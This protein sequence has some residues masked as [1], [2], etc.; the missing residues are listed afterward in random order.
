MQTELKEK[1]RRAWPLMVS[2]GSGMVVLITFLIPSIQDQWDRYQARKVIQEY[3]KLGDEFMEEAH[4]EMAEAA[5]SKAYDLSEER[6]IDIEMKRLHAKIEKISLNS[7]WNSAIPNDIEEVDFLMLMHLLA[8]KGKISERVSIMNTYAI[9]LAA[10]IRFEEAEKIIKEAILLDSTDYQSYINYG[11]LSDQLGRKKDAEK[12]YKK[13]IQL[14]AA[15]ARA[16]YNLG[17]LYLELGDSA[18]AEKQFKT[19]LEIEPNDADARS[20]VEALKKRTIK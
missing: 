20:E 4:F 3:V 19:V 1:L 12:F 17:L 8:S 15:N 13:V 7:D 16:H 2:V 5:Y 18:N 10:N 14:D 11:N 9:F 6:R